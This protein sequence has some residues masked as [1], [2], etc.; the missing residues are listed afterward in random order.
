[1]KTAT[2][3][4]IAEAFELEKLFKTTAI[5]NFDSA[6]TPVSFN[7]PQ[8]AAKNINMWVSLNTKDKI[9]ELINPGKFMPRFLRVG[10][11][12]IYHYGSWYLHF[13]HLIQIQIYF[14]GNY[15]KLVR[16]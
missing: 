5:Q 11:S 15:N 12:Q 10:G 7:N 2:N 8:V 3:V 13:F 1:M 6:V 4:F 14:K 16:V 9:N